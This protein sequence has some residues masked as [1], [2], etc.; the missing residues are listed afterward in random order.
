MEK[1]GSL[2]YE[3]EKYIDVY[4]LMK[5]E[6]PLMKINNKLKWALSLIL[7]LRPCQVLMTYMF[8]TTAMLHM[9]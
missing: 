8:N 5:E 3:R 7:E 6:N 1:Y 4:F 9:C 2:L